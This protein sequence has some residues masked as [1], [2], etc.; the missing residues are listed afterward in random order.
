MAAPIAVFTY[1]RP[2]HSKNTLE[3]LRANALSKESDLFI[4]C[5]GAKESASSEGKMK[6]TENRKVVNAF[7]KEAEG[8]FASITVVAK[9]ENMGLAKSIITGVTDLL[10]RF[11]RI[12]VLE[13]DLITSPDFLSY[14]NRA[15]D[16]YEDDYKI[17]S[18]SGYTFPLKSLE[19]YPHDIYLSPRGCSWG[20][21]TWKDRFARV[22]W[23]V[24]DY[25][26]FLKD[27]AA[28]KHFNEGG[29]DL[30]EML[31]RQM[32]GEIN[33]WAI[34]WCFY[35]SLNSMVTVYP[36]ESL[37]MN[38]GADGS[39]ENC[40]DS[41]LYDTTL[42]E[43]GKHVTFEHLAPD[44]KIMGEFRLMYDYSHFGGLRRKLHRLLMR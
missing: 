15:L 28:K 22:D 9:S 27:K 2:V 19:T 30:C 11:G 17:W 36:R 20:W 39:G 31:D 23:E 44:P 29:V 6:V 25:P 34:R 21:A 43:A 26:E 38:S 18:I 5:D 40:V 35:E 37:V 42:V 3:A 16:Y 1:N 12:I 14:M 41:S 8:D 32:R 13:D 33:S 24:K 7:A 10:E 4:F